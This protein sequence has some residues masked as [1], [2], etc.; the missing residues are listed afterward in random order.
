MSK[1]VSDITNNAKEN[2]KVFFNKL[3]KFS[4]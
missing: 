4:F 1:D 3:D 2:T